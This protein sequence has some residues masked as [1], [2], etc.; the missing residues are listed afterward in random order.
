MAKKNY[1]TLIESLDK[2]TNP[3][4]ILLEKAFSDELGKIPYK[5]AQIYIQ[6]AMRGVEPEYT[7][8]T[9]EA[10]KKVLEK[11]KDELSNVDFEFQGSVMTNTNIKGYSDIDLLTICNKFV[12]PDRQN[13]ERIL[14]DPYSVLKYSQVDR[15]V[16]T[17]AIN[18]PYYTGN[19]LSDLQQL[20]ADDERILKKAYNHVD[21]TNPKS[22]VVSVSTPKRDVDV[23]IANWYN[24]ANYYLQKKKTY[25][26]IQVYNKDLNRALPADYP[27]LSIE[28]I[29]DKDSSVGGRLKK[30]IRFLKTVK[31][32]SAVEIELSSF[33][34]YAICYN[35]EISLYRTSNDLEL[36]SAILFQM[37]S[38]LTNF[39]QRFN[40]QSVDDKE[41][42]FRN[43]DQ[44]TEDTKKVQSLKQLATEIEIILE[45]IKT[46][47]IY[48]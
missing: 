2:R 28:R 5:Y 47:I 31:G 30:M 9:I 33:T 4:K 1:Q 25:R 21:I 45:D 34:I 22:I 36:V 44:K 18:P 13:I 7:Q 48:G 23:V 14:Q 41:F 42:V 12:T 40:L 11:L 29:N 24:N 32:D 16:L 3:E 43:D 20:R 6:K 8:N 15:Q 35:L 38:L 26:G 10:G 37:N 19:Y 46:E 27:F 17:E 39:S